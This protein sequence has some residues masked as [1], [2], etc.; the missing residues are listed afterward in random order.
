MALN[1][2]P[3]LFDCLRINEV[4]EQ[5]NSCHLRELELCSVGLF[6]IFQNPNGLPSSETDLKRQCEYFNESGQCFDDYAQTCLTS[7]QLPMLSMFTADLVDLGRQFCSQ[8]SELRRNY[9]KHVACLREV[10]R[11]HQRPCLTDLQVGFEAIHKIN[12]S[13][14]LATSCW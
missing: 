7:S 2:P 13:L 14:R 11:K 8:S 1:Y 3:H 12:H 4:Q 6:S 5:P 10:Q 9:T